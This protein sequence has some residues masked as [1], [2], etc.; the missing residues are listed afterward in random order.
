MNDT[1]TIVIPK[2][3]LTIISICMTVFMV[4]VLPWIVWQTNITMKLDIKMETMSSIIEDI[5][6]LKMIDIRNSKNIERI[7]EL[8]KKNTDI[9]IKINSI[10]RELDIR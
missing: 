7:T 10:Q 9:Y 6:Y 3:F 2:W 4:I 5:D 8:E 1:Q